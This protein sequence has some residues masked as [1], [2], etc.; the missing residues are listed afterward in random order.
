[1]NLT[2]KTYRQHVVTPTGADD[3]DSKVFS[4]LVWF[5]TWDDAAGG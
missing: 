5:L 2:I 3:A 4:N 1:M